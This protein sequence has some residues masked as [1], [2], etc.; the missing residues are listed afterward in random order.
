MQD[1]RTAVQASDFSERAIIPVH[2]SGRC[3]C[4]G[5]SP[6]GDSNKW[7]RGIAASGIDR[8]TRLNGLLEKSNATPKIF[9]KIIQ[10]IE[11]DFERLTLFMRDGF[12][13][14]TTN[15]IENYYRTTMPDS[16]KRIFKTPHGTLKYL[17]VRKNY[18]LNNI[19]K[20][21]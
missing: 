10:K 14:R 1:T 2:S 13:S 5:V 20:N 19:S 9:H 11:D 4:A 21:I 12:V 15:P 3:E 16:L 17:D 6:T 18:W 7:L 8:L